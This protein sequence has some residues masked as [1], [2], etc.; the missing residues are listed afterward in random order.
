MLTLTVGRPLRGISQGAWR[1]NAG[2][3]G[4]AS[5]SARLTLPPDSHQGPLGPCH[6]FRT[7][8]R[9][10]HSEHRA[11]FKG[12]PS[13]KA[14]VHAPPNRHPHLG[15]PLCSLHSLWL[16]SASSWGL[17][18]TLCLPLRGPSQGACH[19]NTGDWG[20]P[21]IKDGLNLLPGH[22]TATR[23][24][25]C[26][27]NAGEPAGPSEHLTTF[28]GPHPKT[29]G[30]TFPHSSI[31]TSALCSA[32]HTAFG[33]GLQASWWLTLTLGRPP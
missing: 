8:E 11:T 1:H 15:L 28:E 7:R 14:W 25:R 31:L 27:F 26:S 30:P 21:N 3:W 32:R 20:H 2:D 13:Q 22:H 10:G 5:P 19:R 17:T 23:G 24:R 6:S 12:T 9:A 16:C 29:L 18:L 4:P 33:S